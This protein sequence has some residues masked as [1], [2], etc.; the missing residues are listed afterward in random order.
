MDTRDMVRMA[1]QIAAFFKSYPREEGLHD[2]AA[3]INN[4]WDPRMRRQLF[5]HLEKGGEGL[6]PF[7]LEAAKQ[8]RRPSQAVEKPKH[9]A[10]ILPH[11][12]SEG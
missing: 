8:I 1:N 11:G 9:Q 6:D 7:F 10:D 12:E 5:Q 3:H 4:F 2:A